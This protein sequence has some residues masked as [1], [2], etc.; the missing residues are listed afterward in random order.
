MSD[1]PPVDLKAV[2]AKPNQVVIDR[3]EQLLALA[4]TGELRGFCILTN[5]HLSVSA[6]SAGDWDADEAV[7]AAECWKH[8][9]LHHRQENLPGCG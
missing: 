8:R 7:Y 1:R 4:K 6:M 9:Y 3:L 5:E 2:A